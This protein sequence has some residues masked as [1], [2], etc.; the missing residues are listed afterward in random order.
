MGKLKNGEAASED[1]VTGEMI[2]VGGN[3]VVD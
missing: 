2:K 1:E 3:K